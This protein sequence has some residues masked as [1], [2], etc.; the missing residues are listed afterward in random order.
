MEG[1]N[2]FVYLA[3]SME[4]I[5]AV[6]VREVGTN[7][8]PVCFCSKAL[9]GPKTRYH[10]IVNIALSLIIPSTLHHLLS[11]AIMEKR[12]QNCEKRCLRE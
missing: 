6:L 9:A 7:Q 10:K 3:I 2:L 1:E 4:A 8:S 5:S 12:C 11:L